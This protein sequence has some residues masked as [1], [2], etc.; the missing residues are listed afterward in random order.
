M[1]AEDIFAVLALASII[2]IFAIQILTPWLIE[3]VRESAHTQ[4]ER[5]KLAGDIGECIYLILKQN[6]G[7][8]PEHHLYFRFARYSNFSNEGGPEMQFLRLVLERML[9][10]GVISTWRHKT[11]GSVFALNV[12]MVDD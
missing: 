8:I 11:N 5:E 6:E 7:R 3:K 10:S 4:V 1:R 2:G 9:A 12:E